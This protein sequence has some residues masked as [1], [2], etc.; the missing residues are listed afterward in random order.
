MSQPVEQ[1]CPCSLYQ[2]CIH[3]VVRLGPFARTICNEPTGGRKL[4][5]TALLIF[6]YLK[7]HPKTAPGEVAQGVNLPYEM[8]RR[9]LL[10]LK[11]R[12]LIVRSIGGGWEVV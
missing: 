3:S 2:P 9:A 1:H 10:R 8:T 6:N 4:K 12:G 5:G 7:V 11:E